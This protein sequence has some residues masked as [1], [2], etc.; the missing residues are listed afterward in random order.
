MNSKNYEHAI[1]LR[2]QGMTLQMIGDVFQVTR[3]RAR[4]M[5]LTGEE[6]VK[7]RSAWYAGLSKRATNALVK[8]GCTSKDD[9]LAL[10]KSP[11]YL[12][13]GLRGVGV[14][15]TKEIVEWVHE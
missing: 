14:K 2:K 9:V 10:L 3:E 5:V 15:T 11:A 8:R 7:A 13:D 4:Q 12:T 6:M 1:K